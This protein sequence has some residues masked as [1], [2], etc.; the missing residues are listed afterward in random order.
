MIWAIEIHFHYILLVHRELDV[1]KHLLIN[2]II[3]LVYR[4]TISLSIVLLLIAVRQVPYG[5]GESPFKGE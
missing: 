5:Q 4:F 3:V 2:L 1:L